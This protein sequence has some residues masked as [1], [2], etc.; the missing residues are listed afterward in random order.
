VS[1]LEVVRWAVL[2]VP[3]LACLAAARLA[4]PSRRERGAHLLAFLAAF[5]GLGVL[6]E[7]ATIAAWWRFAEVSGSWRGLPVDLWIGWA[8]VWGPLPVALRQ[9]VPLPMAVIGAA[10][11]DALAMPQLTPV[12]ELS[13]GWW[14]G[15]LVGLAIVLVPAALLGRWTAERTDL[16]ARV[17][18]QLLVFGGLV[19]WLLPTT[20]FELG[21]GSWAT[22]L[23]R[24]PT[25]LLG[26][27]QFAAVLALPG[28]AAVHELARAGGTPYP[29]DPPARLVTS[30]PYAFLDNPMQ[31][32][33]TALLL[34]LA[35]L[36]GSWSLALAGVAAT[37]FASTIARPHEHAALRA[38][39]GPAY[40]GYLTAVRPWWPRWRAFV[41]QEAVLAVDGGCARCRELGAAVLAARPERL[42]LVDAR[43]DARPLRRVRYDHPDGG[44]DGLAAIG[45]ALGHAT[46]PWA[47]LGWVLQLP[48][49]RSLLQAI[50]DVVGPAPHRAVREVAS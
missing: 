49:L 27:L 18:G 6:H 11:V 13:G 25:V 39:F 9:H 10:W 29:W 1:R 12:V 28:L 34:L 22:L 19:L 44:E 40:D 23:G 31:W 42:R 35:G 30:G 41:P 46:L 20:V 14:W 15:E 17:V 48:P 38:S 43:D 37:A 8:L 33:A 47:A 26:A 4:P 50:A 21:D 45:R 3:V 7:L 24:S 32:S 2:L 16:G 36:A 5:V